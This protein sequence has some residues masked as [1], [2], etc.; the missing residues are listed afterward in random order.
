MS[1]KIMRERAGLSQ[2]EAAK[3]IGVGQSTISGWET[4]YSHPRFSMLK[5]IAKIFGCSVDD[6]MAKDEEE[7]NIE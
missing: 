7:T 4:G 3:A 1:F 5:Q 2:V 6:L